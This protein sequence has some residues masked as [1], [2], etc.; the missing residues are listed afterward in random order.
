MTL[1]V[2][3]VGAFIGTL[4]ANAGLL[5]FIGHM[6]QKTEKKRLEEFQQAQREMMEAVKKEQERMQKYAKMES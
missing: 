4:T 6:A 3:A 1:L 2:I 5:W